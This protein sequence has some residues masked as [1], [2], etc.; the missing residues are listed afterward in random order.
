M[1]KKDFLIRNQK[2]K[3]SYAQ[4]RSYSFLDA[5]TESDFLKQSRLVR[6]VCWPISVG[7]FT[8]R[9]QH[10]QAEAPRLLKIE[11]SEI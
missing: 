5:P 6:G 10:D 8:G 2:D 4:D 1:V 11:D 7:G 3:M 9:G